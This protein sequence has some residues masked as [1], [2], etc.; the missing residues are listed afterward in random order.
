MIEEKTSL[1]SKNEQQAAASRP[2]V[3]MG[4]KGLSFK[5]QKKRVVE[6]K[7]PVEEEEVVEKKERK[8]KKDRKDR[9]DEK[10]VSA[11]V[12]Q[13]QEMEEEEE[14]V[15]RRPRK[16]ARKDVKR[17]SRIVDDDDI[18][19]EDEPEDSRLRADSAAVEE[20]RR[21]RATSEIQ[22]DDDEAE[23]EQPVKKK[24]KLEAGTTKGRKS[25]KSKKER[26]V[27]VLHVDENDDE[28]QPPAVARIVVRSDLEST[29]SRSPS[30]TSRRPTRAVTPPPTPPPNPIE[31]GLCEDEEDLYFAKL[32][33][34]GYDP[35]TAVAQEEAPAAGAESAP[36]PSEPTSSRKH[37]TGS[38][39]TEGFYKITKQDKAMYLEQYKSKAAAEVIPSVPAAEKPPPQQVMSS[40]SNRANA[41]RRAAGLEEIN[42]VQ[43]AVALSKGETAASELTFKF[44][45]LQTRKKHLRFSRSPIHDW[46]LYAMEKISKGEMVIEYVGEVIRAQVADKREK[47]YEKQ[48]IGSSYL[49][50]IDEE[51]VVDATKKGNLGRLI[52]H[53]CDPNC[54]AKIITISGV[55]KIVI[56]A[57]Q[58]I[59]LGEEITYDYHFPIEQ[60]NKIPC[61][62]GSARCRGYLN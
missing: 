62:C 25:K 42:Q 37:L 34:A 30:P 47:T 51:F 52:N 7:K 20:P 36:E 46:G 19:S 39:R 14:E 12:E 59:E 55:K 54:T 18:E 53:S 28:A 29:T 49:F 57:K 24:V 61:L 48:G 1:A 50:R 26:A 15:D 11:D 40:R 27:E 43:R 33:L 32:A 17:P 56:Y 21:K 31:L 44:N 22:E 23:V 38:A 13:E 4:L 2:K 41:R 58:D 10:A 8:D 9:S 5:K 16:K 60:D 3:K 6:E 45:Q 35:S